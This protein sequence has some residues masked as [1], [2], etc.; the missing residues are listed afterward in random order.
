MSR[1]TSEEI[2]QAFTLV[3]AAHALLAE[4]KQRLIE[5]HVASEEVDNS[6]FLVENHHRLAAPDSDTHDVL[7]ARLEKAKQKL[8]D[9]YDNSE[10]AKI[11]T[12]INSASE[13][14]RQAS[15]IL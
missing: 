10:G 8:S 4:A 13:E 6:A 11:A 7:F 5:L 3:A 1:P 12:I 15:V 14:A 9:Y 2:K